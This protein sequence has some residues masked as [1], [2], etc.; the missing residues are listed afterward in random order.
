[1]QKTVKAQEKV[2]FWMTMAFSCE[3]LDS[4]CSKG[5][6][7]GR[8][9]SNSNISCKQ[10]ESESHEAYLGF[11][12]KIEEMKKAFSADLDEI[13]TDIIASDIKVIID[14][15]KTIREEHQLTYEFYDDL[16]F[17]IETFKN[18]ILKLKENNP[19]LFN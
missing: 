6:E 9:I 10:L 2:W 13:K 8:E 5:I 18:E 1:M 16:K 15:I 7:L 11:H 3:A 19:N 12:D 14:S 4:S 17:L